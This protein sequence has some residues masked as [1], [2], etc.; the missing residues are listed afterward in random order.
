MYVF[1]NYS[2]IYMWIY[3][4]RTADGKRVR[5][6]L[7][8]IQST[9]GWLTRFEM[10]SENENS[11]VNKIS[12]AGVS[13]MHHDSKDLT[14]N[15]AV[16]MFK[17]YFSRLEISQQESDPI[18]SLLGVKLKIANGIIKD[19][20]ELLVLILD[21]FMYAKCRQHLIWWFNETTVSV[22]YIW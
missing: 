5:Q 16:S 1:W 12:S 15:D 10:D 21:M 7:L 4:F 19:L 22:L 20:E 13:L 3:T 6:R 17:N 2:W 11:V 18:E 8:S 9:A 14:S